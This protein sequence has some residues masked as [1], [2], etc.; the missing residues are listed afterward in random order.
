MPGRTRRRVSIQLSWSFWSRR[1]LM[2]LYIYI[3][4][5]IYMYDDGYI[6]GPWSK[7]PQAS[8]NENESSICRRCAGHRRNPRIDTTYFCPIKTKKKKNIKIF[9]HR[10]PTFFQDKQDTANGCA[11]GCGHPRGSS[12][13]EKV[14]FF[15]IIS[16]SGKE[17]KAT[18]EKKHTREYRFSIKQK[19]QYIYRSISIDRYQCL[20]R[21]IAPCRRFSLRNTRRNDRSTVNHG[22][23]LSHGQSSRDGA[24]CSQDFDAERSKAKHARDL[25]AIQHGFN[26][27]NTY[28]IHIRSRMYWSIDIY[29]YR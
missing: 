15:T 13:W 27:G 12:T 4:I 22:S 26:L 5:Y 9:K 23:F 10:R 1:A 6:R 28:M 7:P 16:K 18:R 8:K 20:P 3:Y 25:N 19:E 14:P 17:C 29:I 2:N 11:K 21:I 24:Y